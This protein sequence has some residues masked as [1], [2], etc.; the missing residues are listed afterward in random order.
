MEVWEAI[1]KKLALNEVAQFTIDKSLVSQYPFVAKTL[2]DVHLH[3]HETTHTCALGIQQSGLGYEDLN[4]L[5]KEP[6]DLEFILE[7]VE[8]LQPEDY[9]KETWQMSEDE[10]IERIPKLKEM[11][12][13][14]FKNK[15]YSKAAEHYAQAIGM[16]EQLQLKEKPHD[17]EWTT[18][19][20]QQVPYLL[21]FAQC[22]LFE[23]DFYA[24]IEHCTTVLKTE[25]DNVKALFRRG[26]GHVGAWN[27]DLAREDFN[28][29][30]TLDPSISSIVKKEL[31]TLEDLVKQKTEED[32][33]TYKK[34]FS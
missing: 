31:E 7:L 9:Q 4:E 5:M 20:K 33:A 8:V 25:P 34:L 1:I 23:G 15:N 13:N 6:C 21:N 26:K 14:E 29:A 24:V 3:K 11:G 18:I 16:L 10:R 17:T 2:R 22:K 30:L 32:K 27:P 19:S 28:R 12:N